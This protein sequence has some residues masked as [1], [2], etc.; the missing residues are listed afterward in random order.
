MG[1]HPGPTFIR[2]DAYVD[3][4]SGADTL[5]LPREKATQF[6]QLLMAGG[7]RLQKWIANDDAILSSVTNLSQWSTSTREFGSHPWTYVASCLGHVQI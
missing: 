2:I 1:T 3:I 6:T 4:L 7:F 5:Q